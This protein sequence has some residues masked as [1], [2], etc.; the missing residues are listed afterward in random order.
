MVQDRASDW[1]RALGLHVRAGEFTFWA[2]YRLG[3]PVFTEEGGAQ[4][5]TLQVD[6]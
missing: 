4:H 1:L 6:K 2:K 3:L 5:P